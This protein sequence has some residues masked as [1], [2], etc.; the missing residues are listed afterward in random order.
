MRKFAA[1]LLVII[2][3]FNLVGYRFFYNYEQQKAD[4]QLEASLDKNQYS[5]ADLITIT[6]PL[7]MPYQITQS[8][9]E[10]VNGEVT[11]NGKIYKYVK[12]RIVDG[13]MML[14]CVRD[15]NK[16]RIQNAKTDYFKNA[17]DIASATKKSD[18]SKSNTFKN[19]VS[20]Y[21]HQLALYSLSQFIMSSKRMTLTL[22]ESLLYS[23]HNPLVQPPDVM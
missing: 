2:F 17:N 19:W 4:V 23:P 12:R 16:M 8:N 3:L 1:I 18:N 5:D 20:E 22:N 10:R 9:W 15:A 7:S 6:V 21:D 11:F 13:E 14:M